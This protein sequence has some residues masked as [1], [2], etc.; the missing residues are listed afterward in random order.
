M[1]KNVL[2]SQVGEKEWMTQNT[3]FKFDTVGTLFRAF[4]AIGTLKHE[5]FV[6][7]TFY[8]LRPVIKRMFLW[9][10]RSCGIFFYLFFIFKTT[11]V[12]ISPNPP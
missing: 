5:I 7:L 10:N 1:K 9:T 4:H 11:I 2:N 12:T 8:A 3:S 6:F